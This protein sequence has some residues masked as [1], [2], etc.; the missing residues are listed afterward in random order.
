MKD[1][2]ASQNTAS[3]PDGRGPAVEML[4]CLRI[5]DLGQLPAL[6]APTRTYLIGQLPEPWQW[7][8]KTLRATGNGELFN[9]IK[10][11]SDIT[12]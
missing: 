5:T 2:P 12:F 7:S 10:S 3:R 11:L 6:I 4:N 8:V 1:P 9:E